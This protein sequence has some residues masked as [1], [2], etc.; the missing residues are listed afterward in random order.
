M[1]T[2]SLLLKNFQDGPTITYSRLMGDYCS[3]LSTHALLHQTTVQLC[4][5]LQ[6]S[7]LLSNQCTTRMITVYHLP[8]ALKNHHKAPSWSNCQA[9][10]TRS[11]PL[12]NHRQPLS[13]APKT[14]VPPL[15][16]ALENLLPHQ[17][18]QTP[19]LLVLIR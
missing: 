17:C 5:N 19:A 2:V 6:D 3:L 11:A 18:Q 14:I 16:P 12:L 13:N 7:C 8:L 4:Q 10:C 1:I 9:T 15:L